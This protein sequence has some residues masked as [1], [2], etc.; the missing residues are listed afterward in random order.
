MTKILLIDPDAAL[1]ELLQGIVGREGHDTLIAHDGVRGLEMARGSDPDLLILEVS[2]PNLD[3][4]ALCRMLRFESDIPMIFLTAHQREADRVKGLDLGADDYI[5]KPFLTAELLARIRARLRRS[6]HALHIP[7]RE[8][9][10]AGDLCVDVGSRRVFDGEREI[11]LVAKEFELLV[12]LMRNRG[13]VLSREVLLKHV[14]GDQF[15]NDP[16][17]VDVHIRYLR[18]K[19]DPDVTQPRYIETVYRHGY[20]FADGTSQS[21]ARQANTNT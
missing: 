17:T 15:K 3:G 9:L 2:L 10:T 1:C 14:W 6:D 19:I 11:E 12:V 18:S 21:Q 16:R 5:I 7:K 20:R 13:Q 4:F 8:L